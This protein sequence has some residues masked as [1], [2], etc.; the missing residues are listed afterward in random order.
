MCNKT[1]DFIVKAKAVHGEIY[2][3]AETV[4]VN[5]KT[6]IKIICQTHGV[7]EKTP[8]HHLLGI[9][10]KIC[11]TNKKKTTQDDF[12]IKAKSIHGDRY[13]YAEVNYINSNEKI[14]IMCG[15]HGIFEQK[16]HHHLEGNGCPSCSK[17]KKM[18]LESFISE[19][20]SIH[21][22]RYSYEEVVF[23]STR[24]KVS[25]TC[26]VH[27]SF[28]QTAENHLSGYGCISC[29]NEERRCSHDD[30]IN[31]SKLVHGETYNYDDVVYINY[32]SKVK[33]TCKNH[34][35]FEQRPANHISGS[36][37]PICKNSKGENSIVGI[38]N[39]LNISF[40]AQKKYENCLSSK[41]S[42]LKFDFY[43]E[44]LN[45][46]I[47]FDGIQHFRPVSHFGGEKALLM[48][49]ENDMIKNKYCEEKNISLLRIKYDEDAKA[50][51]LNMLTKINEHKY[52]HIFYGKKVVGEEIT[53]MVFV[54]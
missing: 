48:Q 4:Y 35:I 32:N 25:I 10:C 42:H 43:I 19:A 11:S 39:S 20:N 52:I 49:T 16:P 15:T 47:E 7:F 17:N 41:S 27:G 9:G 21:R 18:T 23:V 13:G 30:F 46:L 6:R 51:I 54:D 28:E 1:A 22:G 26:P 33:I 36:G 50:A 53:D 14:K 45:L 3:Y 2:D 44:Q 5:C 31:K 38:L 8:T 24:F 37:C 40:K 29:A 34:G 12:I